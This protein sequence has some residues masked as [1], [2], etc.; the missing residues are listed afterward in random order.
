MCD[1]RIRAAH[2]QLKDHLYVHIVHEFICFCI[3]A[4]V[5]S[6]VVIQKTRAGA[7]Y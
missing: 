7:C 4:C 2:K 5:F 6:V 3:S 1:G